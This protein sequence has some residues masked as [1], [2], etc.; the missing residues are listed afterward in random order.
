MADQHSLTGIVLRSF[1]SKPAHPNLLT[2]EISVQPESGQV[3]PYAT[4]DSSKPIRLKVRGRHVLGGMRISAVY[5]YCTGV[6]WVD[7][8]DILNEK[9]ESIHT[10]CSIED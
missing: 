9:G 4:F 5:R 1:V 6:L 7:A 10:D 8:Y 2:T 3:I